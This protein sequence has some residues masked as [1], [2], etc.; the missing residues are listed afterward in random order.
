MSGINRAIRIADLLRQGRADE[1]LALFHEQEMRRGSPESFVAYMDRIIADS[2]MSRT[3]II[4]RSGLSR[5]YMY[6]VLRGDKTT[7]ERDYIIAFCMAMKLD[8]DQTQHA[9]ELYP[10]PNLSEEDF[11]SSDIMAA[12]QKGAGID[13][14]NGWLEKFS[15]PLLRTSPDMPAAKIRPE[16]S[17]LSSEK[18]VY[19]GSE[20]GYEPLKKRSAEEMNIT[21]TKT[22]VEQTGLA[23]VDLAVGAEYEFVTDE[24][25]TLY[26]QAFF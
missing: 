3:R 19:S 25:R 2:G 6:K 15:Q 10:F 1:A 26:A 12:I 14:L 7:S 13:E 5:D 21:G 4:Q 9:L 11:R 24:G 20:R 8:L 23:P 16:R 17:T 22:S 18:P